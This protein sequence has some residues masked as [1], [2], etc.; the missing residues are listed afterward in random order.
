MGHRATRPVGRD[1]EPEIPGGLS[2]LMNA[3]VDS[4]F[5]SNGGKFVRNSG[6]DGTSTETEQ[7]EAARP[8][9]AAC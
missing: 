4:C 9:I 3:I 8:V 7:P 2:A 6:A 5:R 1:Y